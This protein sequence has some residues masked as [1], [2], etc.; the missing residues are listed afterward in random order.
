MP[1]DEDSQISGEEQFT[2]FVTLAEHQYG[3]GLHVMP[4]RDGSAPV[5]SRV[6][7]RLEKRQ[8]RSGLLVTPDAA[9]AQVSVI[10]VV[11]SRTE[12]HAA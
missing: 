4:P 2:W 3:R 10:Y 12:G 11:V 1:A 7:P 9:N 5:E 6:M 8:A